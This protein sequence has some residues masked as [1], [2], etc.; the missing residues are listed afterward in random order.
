MCKEAAA[1]ENNKEETVVSASN[2]SKTYVTFE[3]KIEV[4]KDLGLEVQK[5]EF[6]AVSGASGSGKTT[7][8]NILGGIDKPTRGEL[9][10]LGSDLPRKDED[11]LAEF[12]SC[13][14][15]FVFQAYN[16]ISILTVAENIAFP[17]EWLRKPPDYIEKRV[18]KLLEEVGLQARTNHFPSQLSGGEQQRVAFARALANDPP[19]LLIDE[20]TANLDLA[21]RQ[22]I[23]SILKR[24]KVD[25]KTII[26]T[27]H[28]EQISQLAD[29][30]LCLENGNLASGYA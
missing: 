21:T 11:F 12:R 14:V 2:L 22:R 23:I 29:R 9:I 24:L 19:L 20:P 4:L 6:V 17:M 8:L 1:K 18:T 15:G 5:G 26:V 16:L 13:N 30:N 10:V 7:L 27:T 3:S 25:R 28:D